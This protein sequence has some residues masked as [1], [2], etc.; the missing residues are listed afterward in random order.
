M[1]NLDGTGP[2]GQG[3]LKGRR[4]GKCRDTEKGVTKDQSTENKE[5]VYGLGRGGRPHDGGGV[6]YGQN[7]GK[8]FGRNHTSNK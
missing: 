6:G 3:A 4:R 5:V 1:P 2:Q 7:R 8:G